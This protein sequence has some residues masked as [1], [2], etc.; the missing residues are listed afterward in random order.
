[1]S[2]RV[3][4]ASAGS[5]AAAVLLACGGA[6]QPAVPGAEQ[7]SPAIAEFPEPFTGPIRMVELRDG[8]VLLMDT[9]ERRLVRVDFTL[10]SL[11]T[12]SRPGDG[13]LEYR[14]MFVLAPAPQDGVWGFDLVRRR[15]LE[16]GPDGV[17]LSSRDAGAGLDGVVRL[18]APWLRT[19]T[20]DGG[21]LG[22]AV[23]FGRGPG[24]IA[25]TVWVLRVR[26]AQPVPDT[27]VSLRGRA[28]RRTAL[29]SHVITAFD[30]VD[31]WAGF[32]D[33][34]VLVVR[35]DEYRVWL[36]H[37]DGR[38]EDAGVVP[39]RRVP[40]TRADAERVRDS[41]AAELGALVAATMANVPQLRDRPA[42]PTHVLPEP[43]PRVWPLLPDDDAIAIDWQQR[44]WLRVR[45]AAFDSGATR[46]D[47]LDRDGRFLQAV[48]VPAGERV[49]GFGREAVYVAR[50]D[51]DQLLWLRK[52]PLP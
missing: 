10:G 52:Y 20:S 39:H 18:S 45:T 34:R 30:D 41:V 26:P 25:D 29:G 11:D 40:L 46:Y 33:G 15:I 12:I 38:V 35:G 21:W 2:R 22:R 6:Q 8:R 24:L 7:L 36:H 49:V 23:R 9:R 47:I 19:A 51:A 48:R 44:A 43:L 4:F 28:P 3:A 17:P 37:P 14:T 5:C 16:F 27:V 1:M 50:Q 42:P 32:A 13:P 31:A